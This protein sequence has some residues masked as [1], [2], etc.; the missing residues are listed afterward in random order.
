[1]TTTSL[2]RVEVQSITWKGLTWL[3]VERPTMAEMEYLR[4]RFNFHP[5]A[6]DDCLSRVQLPKVDEFDDHIFLVVH[7][8]LFNKQ[9]RLTLPSQVAIFA[10]AHYVVTVH[11]GELKPLVKLF[12]DCQQS[13]AVRDELMAR[14]SGYLLYRILDVLVDYCFPILGKIMDQVDEVEE[15]L[16]ERGTR[17]VAERLSYIRRDIIAFRRIIRPQIGVME[18]LERRE[19]P[20]LK[21]DPDVYFGDLADHTRRIWAELEELREVTQGLNE[22]LFTLSN[23]LTN[24][25]LRILTVIFTALLPITI[26]GTL[27]GMNLQLPIAEHPQAF[28]ITTGAGI[29]LGVVLWWWFRLNKWV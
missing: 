13:E 10:G 18:L 21:V 24:D 2:A 20:F 16:F 23:Q 8:P 5:L 29:L 22:T 4:A 26:I 25:A 28:W 9:M 17:Q 1:M 7:F 3:N 6:L 11:R 19:Y 15:H 27:Y 12:T 14:S